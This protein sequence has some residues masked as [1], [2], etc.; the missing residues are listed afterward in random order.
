MNIIRNA[1]A[2]KL[3]S[4]AEIANYDKLLKNTTEVSKKLKVKDSTMYK[5]RINAIKNV[6][7]YYKTATDKFQDLA[8]KLS[9]E[10]GAA[11]TKGDLNYFS[12]LDMVY[13]FE[14]AAYNTA[15]GELSPIV[16]TRFGYH[17]L[18]VYDKRA[19]RG[20]ILVSHIMVKFP[21]QATDGDKANAK[22]KIDEIYGKFKAGS[23]I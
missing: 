18:K 11:E 19:S 13:P 5:A 16:R 15:V 10:P 9:E 4:A 23:G 22:T 2:G 14:S 21:K 12:A 3:P 1:V 6:S 8:S 7:D 17:V 20:E